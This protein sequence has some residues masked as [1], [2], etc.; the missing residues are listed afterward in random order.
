MCTMRP[1][2]RWSRP[3]NRTEPI[4]PALTHHLFEQ[5]AARTP[6]AVAVVCGAETLTY[7]ELNERANQAAH[8]L[9]RRGIGPDA[10]AAVCMERTP[11]LVVAL[12]AVWKAGGAYVP[13]DPAY[14]KE[15]LEFMLGDAN[16]RAL[17]TER[18]LR[19][20]LPSREQRTICL[21]FHAPLIARES[22]SNP[23]PAATP[24]NLS[25]VM[26]TSRSTG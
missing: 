18:N 5:Q 1:S 20:L 26:Y 11:L 3:P 8:Y 24:A 15:R 16:P 2:L 19:R 22:T 12:L 4:M 23:A 21:D 6:D 13:L 17:I 14:P 10:L 25:Y 9:R 7:R